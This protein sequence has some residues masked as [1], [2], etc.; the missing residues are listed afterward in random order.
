[1]PITGRDANCN[2]LNYDSVYEYFAAVMLYKIIKLDQYAYFK[3]L[4]DSFIPIHIYGT[5]FFHDDKFNIPQQSHVKF[6][7][8]FIFQAVHTLNSLPEQAKSCGSLATFK[9]LN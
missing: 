7:H 2:F 1:M 4:L 6:Q 5:R 9:R 3:Q 8:C